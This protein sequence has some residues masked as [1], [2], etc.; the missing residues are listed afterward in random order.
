[1]LNKQITLFFRKFFILFFIFTVI[2]IL[3]TFIIF[4]EKK[5]QKKLLPEDGLSRIM[6][7]GKIRMIT[8]NRS[9]CY[10][11]YRG[12]HMGFEYEL[13]REFAAYLQVE[14]EV[15]T[16]GWNSMF[17]WLDMDYGDFIAAGITITEAREQRMLFSQPYMDVQQ[18]FIHHKSKLPIKSIKKLPGRTLHIPAKTSYYERL[19]EIKAEGIDVDMV[20]HDDLNSEEILRMIYE[21]K[22]FYTIVDSSVAMLNRRYYPDIRIGIPINGTEHLAWAVSPSNQ[23]LSDKIVIFFDIIKSNGIY[24]KIY[25]KYF[26]NVDEFDYFD[27]YKFHKRIKTRLPKYKKTI[28]RE[29]KKY[30]F[31]WRMIAAMIYQESHFDPKARSKTGVRGLMQ[32]TEETAEEMNITNRRDP[33]QS[34]KAGIGYLKEL[35]NKFNDINDS[36]DRMKFAMASY[37]IGYGHVLDAR[38]LARWQGMADDKWHSIKKTLPLLAKKKFYQTVR[39]GYARG[40][41]PVKYIERIFIYYDILKQKAHTNGGGLSVSR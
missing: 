23:R 39:Y 8:D 5:K 40:G 21:K 6:K 4:I 30:G 27:L 12:E 17:Y 11:I 19:M 28:Q 3:V 38:R 9:N 29:C 2:V 35:H 25:D 37:N 1:M 36:L 10:Y 7:E 26:S 18:R 32:I 33:F 24:K 20:V 14:L 34:L 13:A 22:F 16:P 41:E 15:H 31:D